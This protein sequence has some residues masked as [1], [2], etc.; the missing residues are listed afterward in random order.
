MSHELQKLSQVHLKMVELALAGWNQKEMAE[1]MQCTTGSVGLI[2][3]SGL[4]QQ[5]LSRRRAE[6]QK[7]LDS[8]QLDNLSL[9]RNILEQ[10]APKA[11]MAMKDLLDSTDQRVRQASAV[12][13]LNR[14]L[15]K[16]M[17]AG[18]QAGT[19]IQLGPGS[20]L[21]LQQAL[22]ESAADRALRTGRIV[23]PTALVR[24]ADAPQAE[25]LEQSDQ[26]ASES[27]SEAA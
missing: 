26:S 15:G 27:P 16:G 23:E 21:V 25:L 12:D 20:L 7:Q 19:V 8:G 6:Q 24:G 22:A 1:A 13:I 5:E 10:N 18:Q 4:F 17:E 3:K 14:T 2:V 9:A 11:A